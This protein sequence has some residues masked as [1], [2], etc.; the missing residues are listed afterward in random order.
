[1][2]KHPTPRLDPEWAREARDYFK[3]FLKGT[4]FPS[5]VRNGT[6]GIH[7]LAKEHW[8]IIAEGLDLKPI[9]ESTLRI[10]LKKSATRLEDLQCSF[11]G[12]PAN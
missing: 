9:A 7:R 5:P 3:Q 1:M 12:S 10:R 2:P 4:K 8:D 11:F 6:I